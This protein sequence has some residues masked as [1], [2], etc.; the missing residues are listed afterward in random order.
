MVVVVQVST[1]CAA[2]LQ[3]Y[4]GLQLTICVVLSVISL[5]V[6]FSAMN[7][8]VNSASLTGLLCVK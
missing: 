6:S 1:C 8:G 2:G 5:C 4:L 7:R 3:L